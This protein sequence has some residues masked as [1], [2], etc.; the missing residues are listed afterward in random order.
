[1]DTRLLTC[2]P[3]SNFLSRF[4]SKS[5]IFSKD[6]FKSRLYE[7]KKEDMDNAMCDFGVNFWKSKEFLLKFDICK[8]QEE[9]EK[10]SIIKKLGSCNFFFNFPAQKL[11]PV[12][13]RIH[14]PRHSGV[15]IAKLIM[16]YAFFS[17]MDDI[18]NPNFN[19]LVNFL[20]N[21]LG[22]FDNGIISQFCLRLNQ[23]LSRD[24]DK[25]KRIKIMVRYTNLC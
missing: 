10:Y 17:E 12:K 20:E 24:I 1:M 6:I 5:A 21:K 23:L 11:E 19:L 3:F 22:N 13:L 14:F 9:K 16:N 2:K 25:K 8:S 15:V 18:K 7:V 4:W